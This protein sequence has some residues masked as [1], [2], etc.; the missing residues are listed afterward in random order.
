MILQG[1]DVYRSIVIEVQVQVH[2]MIR[3]LRESILGPPVS[4]K[5]GPWRGCGRSKI[6]GLPRK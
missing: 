6:L 2:Y 5:S 1:T 4:M 3:T